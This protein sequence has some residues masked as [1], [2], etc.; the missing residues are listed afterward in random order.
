MAGLFKSVL[1]AGKSAMDKYL[2]S[3]DPNLVKAVNPKDYAPVPVQDREDCMILYGPRTVTV[4]KEQLQIFDI[5]VNSDR[6]TNSSFSLCRLMNKDEIV[7]RFQLYK[8]YIPIIMSI[9]RDLC[10]L[11]TLQNLCDALKENETL[12]IAHL[13]VQLDLKT[14]LCHPV[15]EP[16]YNEQDKDGQT[17]IMIAVKRQNVSAIKHL[18]SKEVDLARKDSKLNNVFH[19]TATTNKEL[20]EMLGEN[21]NL[22]KERNGEGFTPLHIACM[23]DMPDCVQAFLCAGADVNMA[24]TMDNETPLET[25]VNSSNARCVKE[26]IQMYPKQLHVQVG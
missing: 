7:A 15:T 10:N 25:A 4:K 8:H 18:V 17:P 14:V 19:F 11:S 13:A 6:N 1:D 5:V 21:P 2:N 12:T 26:I 20:I 9:D 16:L 24:G 22:L 3:S 23:E